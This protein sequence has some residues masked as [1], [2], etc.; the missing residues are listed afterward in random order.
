MASPRSAGP[1]VEM[2]DAT[3]EER[4]VAQGRGAAGGARADASSAKAQGYTALVSAPKA[5]GPAP[6]HRKTKIPQF[7]PGPHLPVGLSLLGYASEE[8][9]T[10]EAAALSQPLA[11]II[12]KPARFPSFLEMCRN[13]PMAARFASY[14]LFKHCVVLPERARTLQ[15]RVGSQPL[16]ASDLKRLE[17]L[18]VHGEDK[19]ALE[20]AGLLARRLH[21]WMPGYPATVR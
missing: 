8:E 20:L 10:A 9:S 1:D 5:A 7:V 14:Q 4:R 3:E 13:T 2:K 11:W 19:E 12:D 15:P 21:S 16:A 18:M 6:T 17:Q